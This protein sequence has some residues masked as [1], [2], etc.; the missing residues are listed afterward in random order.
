MNTLIRLL[1]SSFMSVLLMSLVVDTDEKDGY[2]I[3]M[4][5]ALV[6][7]GVFYHPL[8]IFSSAT[9]SVSMKDGAPITR[10]RIRSDRRNKIGLALFLIGLIGSGLLIFT[11]ESAIGVIPLA[12]M[13][14]GLHLVFSKQ[15]PYCG[16]IN[17]SI[18]DLCRNCNLRLD[19]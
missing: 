11:W 13:I 17:N 6:M 3:F 2:L 1:I 16:K 4:L 10:Y 14:V 9:A 15:C 5:G 18:D 19:T 7:A 12:I 8:T